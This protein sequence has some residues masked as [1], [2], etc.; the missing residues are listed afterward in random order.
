MSGLQV[1][2][3]RKRKLLIRCGAAAAIGLAGLLAV[4]PRADA[5]DASRQTVV[6]ED[7]FNALLSPKPVSGRQ[8]AILY[9][10]THS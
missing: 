8:F 1:L 5:N 7:S 2:V 3:Q 10:M 4:L 6:G 9:P